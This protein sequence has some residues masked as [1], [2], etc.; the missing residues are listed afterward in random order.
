MNMC[1][2]QIESTIFRTPKAQFFLEGK[3]MYVRLACAASPLLPSWCAPSLGAPQGCRNLWHVAMRTEFT[4][5]NIVV[6]IVF[7][8]IEYFP[9]AARTTVGRGSK[10]PGVRPLCK[11]TSS[12]HPARKP[13]APPSN[14]PSTRYRRTRSREAAPIVQA[15]GGVH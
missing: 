12:I 14:S 10:A 3:R 4:S 8:D 5:F 2:W 15:D 6:V 7:L 1:L 9:G 11:T 13:I